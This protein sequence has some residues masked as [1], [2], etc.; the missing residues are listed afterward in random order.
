MP[1]YFVYFKQIEVEVDAGLYSPALIDAPNEESAK[2]KFAHARI[3]LD[4]DF[5]QELNYRS[6]DGVASHFIY[7]REQS[8]KYA[9]SDVDEYDLKKIHQNVNKILNNKEWADMFV[10]HF[11]SPNDDGEPRPHNLPLEMIA[12]LW[13]YDDELGVIDI[14]TLEQL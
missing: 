10:K 6:T 5:Q 13:L 2:E 8:M 9:Q 7:T 14:N 1:K 4:D 11:F 3:P 12:K